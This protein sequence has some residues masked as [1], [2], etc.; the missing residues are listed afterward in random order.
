MI[1]NII[2]CMVCLAMLILFR[3]LDRTNIK[4][5][6]LRR[7]SS[8]LFDE[9]K[10]LAE[11][12]NRRFNDATIEM[13]IMIKKSNALAKIINSS[14]K[15]IEAKLQGLDIEKSNL[16]KVEEDIRV[17]SQSA[18]DVNKQIEFIAGAKEGFNEMTLNMNYLRESI[19]G[20]KGESAEMLQNF[21]ARLKERSRELTAEFTDQINKLRESIENKEDILVNN[22]RQKLMDLTEAYERALTD[23]DQRVTDTGEILL[24]NFKARIDGIAKSVEGASNLQNQIEVLK[25]SLNDLEGK[26]FSDIKQ[27]SSAV[28]NEIQNSINT[29]YSKVSTV[30]AN[31]NDSKAKLIKSFETE[32]EKVRSEMDNLSIHAITKRDEIVQASRREAEEVMK[33][34]N[35]FEERFMEFETR[36]IN[37][38]DIKNNELRKNGDQMKEE[39]G[40]M[41]RR[42]AEIKSEILN[43]EDQNK[44]FSKTEALMRDV[45]SSI[46][47]LNRMLLESQKEAQHLE[48]FFT[49]MDQIKELSKDFDREIRA[50]QNKKEKLADIEGE[51]RALQDMGDT[52]ME[53]TVAL[54]DEFSKVD[55]V[56]SRI[57]ALVE[58]YASLES[59]I[60]ELHDYEDVITRNLD[61]VNKADI[62]I[63][64]VEGKINAFQKVVD[65]SEKRVDR[66]NQNIRGVEE[67]LLI[68]KTRESDIKEIK[69]KFNEL[70]GLSEIMEV[71]VKQ[72]QAMFNKVEKL[73]DEIS[74]TDS[75]LQELFTETDR[76]MR[77]FADFIQAVDNNN[78]IL[79]QVKGGP[80]TPKNI[81][82]NVIRTVRDL[83]NKGWTSDEISRKL[84][85]DENAVRLIINTTSL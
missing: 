64:S 82:D 67:N 68:L 34:I 39:F 53:K 15:E 78:P 62:L 84:M 45:D 13:D 14:V 80:A 60:R 74:S 50:Y 30:E 6:K 25:L 2:T 16:K 42:L 83:S 17:I 61:S 72:I 59:R 40:N 63:Q 35:N 7:Y 21:S 26:V 73:R 70:D 1:I 65:R 3:K 11:T 46:E 76:K 49:D 5:A 27:R 33:V 9:F 66:I 20:L 48:K 38:A 71:R 28:E 85:M 18:R 69:D 58:S 12:E 55:M 10:T 37:T 41:E 22:S 81:N 54:R 77:Q 57:D 56:S 24:Q 51:I 4:M 19:K 43:Y 31:M 23:M 79:K 52:A 44:I 32:V 8:R 29:L 36:I 47:K 75:H